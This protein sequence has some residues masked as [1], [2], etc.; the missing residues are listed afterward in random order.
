MAGSIDEA[1]IELLDEQEELIV[2]TGWMCGGLI[3]SLGYRS[4]ASE[5]LCSLSAGNSVISSF[6]IVMFF[7]MLAIFI[8]DRMLV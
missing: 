5:T 2:G 8:K 3:A 1:E 6:M 7:G 4:T